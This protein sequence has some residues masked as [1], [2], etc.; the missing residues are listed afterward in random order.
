MTN[1]TTVIS[2]ETIS[3][4]QL[5]EF[6]ARAK[7]PLVFEDCEFEGADLSRLALRG[8]NFKSC[9]LVEVS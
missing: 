1:T 4:F 9:N 6:I 8:V 2:G 7:A 5:E 3:R